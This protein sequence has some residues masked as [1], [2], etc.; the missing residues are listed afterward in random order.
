MQLF[1]LGKLCLQVDTWFGMESLKECI[2][3]TCECDMTWYIYN[4]IR[5][6]TNEE[7]LCLWLPDGQ[8]TRPRNIYSFQMSQ[9]GPIF[10]LQCK[11]PKGALYTQRLENF[12]LSHLNEVMTQR[13]ESFRLSHLNEVLF[14]YTCSLIGN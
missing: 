14:W 8:W 11:E 3:K 2:L 5:Y 9:D 10:L 4:L 1:W 7:E 12:R 6:H 13:L